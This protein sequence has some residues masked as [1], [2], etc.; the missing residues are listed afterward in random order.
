M[1][2]MPLRIPGGW[3]VV[4]NAFLDVS[5]EIVNGRISPPGVFVQDILSIE[6]RIAGQPPPSDRHF[7]ID[8]GW[9]PDE[10]PNGGFRL[11]VLLSN[12]DNVLKSIESRDREIIRSTLERWLDICGSPARLEAVVRK[13]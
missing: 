6:R 13:L 1:T 3:L 5:P 11:A 2:L 7:I 12:W 4:K 9:Y 8:L 10:D